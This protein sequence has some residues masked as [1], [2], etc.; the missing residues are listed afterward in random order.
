MLRMAYTV[1]SKIDPMRI[2]KFFREKYS[3][4]KIKILKNLLQGIHCR[5]PAIGDGMAIT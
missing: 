3:K 2:R 5:E 1:T 4:I